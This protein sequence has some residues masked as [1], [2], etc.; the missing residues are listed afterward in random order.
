MSHRASDMA[1]DGGDDENGSFALGT[2]F[3][4]S[5]EELPFLAPASPT[6]NVV[7][8]IRRHPANNSLPP[9]NLA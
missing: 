4:V 5:R 9:H 7:P 1:A 8:F 2:I 6:L 3:T